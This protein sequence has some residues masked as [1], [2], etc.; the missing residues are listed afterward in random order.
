VALNPEANLTETIKLST[1]LIVNEKLDRVVFSHNDLHSITEGEAIPGKSLT[2]TLNAEIALDLSHQTIK[3]SDLQIKS[4]DLKISADIS[5]TAIKDHAAFQGTVRVEEFSPAKVL[6][7]WDVALP[8]MQ[9][10]K[11]LSKLTI[12]FELQATEDSVALQN[13]LVNLDD[14]QLKGS[15]QVKDFAQP[16]ITFHLEADTI[17]ADRYLPP[18]TKKDKPIS[19]PASALAVGAASMPVDTLRNSKKNT[20]GSL[21]SSQSSNFIRDRIQEILVLMPTPANR[22]WLLTKPSIMFRLNPY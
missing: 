5:G 12:N 21:H 20:A 1:T 15:I 9:D 6:K 4:G 19:S 10:N 18:A 2:A 22:P 14:S 17:D 7:E 16:A 13:V 11:A 8:V 3:M